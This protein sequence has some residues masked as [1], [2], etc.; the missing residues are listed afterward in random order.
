MAEESSQL[1]ARRHSTKDD[2]HKLE[3]PSQLQFLQ[4]LEPWQ[5]LQLTILYQV[6][7][8]LY[9]CIDGVFIK[10]STPSL[11]G[12]AEYPC[13]TLQGTVA[14][15]RTSTDSISHTD[16]QEWDMKSVFR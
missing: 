9:K 7:P 1:T 14:I 16:A 5:Q 15:Q 2:E 4:D 12:K 3:L 8:I 11:C 10:R 6:N 13:D